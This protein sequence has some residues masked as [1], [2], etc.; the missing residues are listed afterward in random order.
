MNG[1]SW[2]NTTRPAASL[3]VD[4]DGGLA[5]LMGTQN[6]TLARE[7]ALS[8]SAILQAARDVLQTAFV[9]EGRKQFL[10]PFAPAPERNAE[11]V[12]VLRAA[13]AEHRQRGGVLG[14]VPADD[15]TL[16]QLF[17]AT[18]GWGPAQRYLDD[19]RM[20][21]VKIVGR[22]IRVQEAG[23]PFVT[24]PEAFTSTDEVQSRALLLASVLGVRLDAEIPQA[25]LPVAHGTRMHVS[26]PPR[27]VDGALICIRRGR[28][29]AWD[30]DDVLKRGTLDE[31]IAELLKLFSRARC[32]MLIA[33]RTGSGKTGLLEA[34]ANSWPGDPHTLTIEDHTMEIGIRRA[35]IWTRELV[36]TQRDPLAF[37]RVAREALR[38]TPDLLL[39]GEIRGN[40]AGAILALVLSDHPVISTLHARSCQEA[41]ERFA[42]CAA[43]PGAYMYEGRREDGLRDASM[44]FDVLIK[45]DFWEESGRRLVTEIALLDGAVVEHGVV[46]PR[47]IP[48]VKVDVQPDG[49]IVWIAE[50]RVGQGG[51]LEWTS[52]ADR[53]PEPL[54]EKLKRARALAQ[55]R[56]AAT[57][58]DVVADAMGRAERLLLASEPERALATLKSAWAQRRDMRLIGVAQRAL[59]QAPTTFADITAIAIAQ[60]TDLEQLMSVRRWQ[61]ARTAY[62]QVLADLASAAAAVPMGGW[63]HVDARIR[64]GLAQEAEAQ[65]A[66]MEA[67]TALGQV[68][69]HA[70][71]DILKRFTVTDLPRHVALPVI[72]VRERALE[73]LRARGEG[74]EEA[75]RTVRVQRA[76]LEQAESQPQHANDE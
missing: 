46:K 74:S 68:H 48:L 22:R 23:K 44:G 15:E 67:E 76:A 62:E 72:Q 9:E 64:A 4:E 8:E 47:V 54:R 40:E 7:S 45:V 33:G 52:G 13:I 34:L 59:A 14:C 32:S 3:H 43:L 37:G 36:D 71:I 31:H 55:I 21:E 49:K 41:I 18:L 29:E 42:S 20:N 75:L 39:P 10:D 56:A 63:E 27:T 73:A 58:L 5:A 19:V 50:A 57:T 51:M 38:Q 24:A 61:E 66:R 70:A 69:P 26:I 60:F 12:A 28:R 1:Q 6:V 16:L 2:Q 30:L 25:T 35:D 53:T 11:V 65:E 17:A